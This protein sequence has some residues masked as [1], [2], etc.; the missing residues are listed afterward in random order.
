MPIK[1][2]QVTLEGK[3][4]YIA[5]DTEDENGG[6]CI[7]GETPEQAIINFK[8]EYMP[9]LGSIFKMIHE[10]NSLLQR[11]NGTSQACRRTERA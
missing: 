1:T 7:D 11:V 8:R 10:T 5:Y 3:Q 4:V 2:Q 9:S 6:P